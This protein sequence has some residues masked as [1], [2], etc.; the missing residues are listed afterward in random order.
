MLIPVVR[1]PVGLNSTHQPRECKLAGKI[2]FCLLLA[3]ST[4]HRVRTNELLAV[5]Y[6]ALRRTTEATGR[7]V[8]YER[9]DNSH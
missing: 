5:K 2:R 4:D 8:R 7:T 1:F 6:R 3:L 9:E